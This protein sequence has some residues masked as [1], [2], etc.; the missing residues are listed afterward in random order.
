MQLAPVELRVR[1]DALLRRQHMQKP[2]FAVH[3]E[4]VTIAGLSERNCL[5]RR[6]DAYQDTDFGLNE[7]VRANRDRRK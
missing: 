6:T 4:S 1:R 3:H 7:D 5:D 2:S